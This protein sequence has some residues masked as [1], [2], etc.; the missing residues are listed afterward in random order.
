MECLQPAVLGV[1]S[2]FDLDPSVRKHVLYRLDGGSGTD[3]NLSWLLNRNYQILSKGFSGK[4]AKALARQVIRWDVY[5]AQCQI[6]RVT[7]TFDLGRPIDVLVKRRWHKKQWRHS[8]YVSTLTSPSK[9]AFMDKYNHRGAA[10]IEQFRNDKQGLGLSTRRKQQLQA[11]KALV[12]LNDLCHNLLADFCHR[13]LADSPF[14]GWG[15]KRIVRDLLAVPGRLYLSDGQLKRIELLDTHPYTD[16]LI[17]CL[18]KYC[19]TPF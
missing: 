14:S 7:P 1:E 4:R 17:I 2:S 15:N 5:D 19:S 16:D 10:E 9:R 13:G 18:E 11:Q 3:E 12:L 8:Y 6:G